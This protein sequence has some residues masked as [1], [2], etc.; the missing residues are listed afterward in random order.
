[1]VLSDYFPAA[2]KDR[3]DYGIFGHNLLNI[4]A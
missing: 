4:S 1:M 3:G 2:A